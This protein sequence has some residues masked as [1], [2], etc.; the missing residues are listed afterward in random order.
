MKPLDIEFETNANASGLHTFRQ[1]KSGVTLTGKPVYI[2]E[3]LF[4]TGEK[5]GKT[6]GFEV[7]VPSIKKAGTYALPGG[8]TITYEEDFLEYPGASKFGKSAWSYPAHLPEAAQAKFKLLT[9]API[10]L[11]ELVDSDEPVALVEPEISHR[12]RPRVD[13]PLLTMPD[14]E[15]STAELA[16]LNKTDYPVA[17]L[18]LK[19]NEAA[20]KVRR[21]RTERRASRG[22]ATQLYSKV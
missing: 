16:N 11:V 20:G 6:F 9:E 4:A 1:I 5:Q 10:E 8:K 2:Y 3:R 17:A 19:D 7:V 15:F 22:K 14:G 21:T 12:G 18:F 13:R